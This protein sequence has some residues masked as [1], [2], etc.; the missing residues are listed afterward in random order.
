MTM[1]FKILRMRKPG[2]GTGLS[3]SP[4]PGSYEDS[5]YATSAN[6]GISSSP[7]TPGVVWTWTKS[8]NVNAG[9]APTSGT[10]AATFSCYLPAASGQVRTA[11]F[12]VNASYLSQN[13]GPWTITL[14]ADWT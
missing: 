8:G 10:A 4:N 1:P 7:S 3:F 12:T 11:T 9:G 2:G 14:T 6:F 13:Y 5:Q